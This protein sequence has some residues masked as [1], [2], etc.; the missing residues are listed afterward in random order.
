MKRAAE[1]AIKV[2][3]SYEEAQALHWLM[4]HL[5]FNDALQ[6]TPPRLDEDLRTERAYQIVHAASALQ[7]EIEKAHIHGNGWMYRE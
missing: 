5:G 2:T 4:R 1:T 6:S 3:L 7:N